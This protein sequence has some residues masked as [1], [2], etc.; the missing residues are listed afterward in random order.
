MWR[1]GVTWWGSSVPCQW[2]SP[3]GGGRHPRHSQG[4]NWCFLVSGS[5]TSVTSHYRSSARGRRG[6]EET[7][8]SR[9]SWPCSPVVFTFATLCFIPIPWPG[10]G[11]F[12]VSYQLCILWFSD[13]SK[14]WAYSVLCN[15]SNGI[16]KQFIF[17][18]TDFSWRHLLRKVSISLWGES[19]VS[20]VSFWYILG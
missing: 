11:G 4:G 5:W 10:I 19:A 17:M 2:L 15:I 12:I 7:F 9:W 14:P 8:K 13:I 3:L 1:R 6:P 20:Y 16:C 18:T